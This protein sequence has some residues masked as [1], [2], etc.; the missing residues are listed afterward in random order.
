MDNKAEMNSALGEY[1]ILDLTDEKGLLCGK[2][3]GDL[4]ADVI[5]IEKPGGD[6]ARNI[7]PYYGDKPDPEK[8]LFWFAYNAN[9]RG[10]TLDI[11][12][13]KGKEVFKKLVDDA[14]IVI[15]SF[16]P[17]YLDSI[18]LGYEVLEEINPGI[19]LTSISPFGQTGP[20]KDYKAPDIILW[21]TGGI[22]YLC[23]DSDRAP[24]QVSSPQAYLSG[25]AEAAAATMI[26]LYHRETTGE[27]Q[28][29]DVSIHASIPWIAM[30]GPEFWPMMQRNIKRTGIFRESHGTGVLERQIWRCKD[31]YVHF[32][33]AGGPVGARFMPGLLRWLE[34]EGVNTEAPKEVNWSDFDMHYVS[35]EACDAIVQPLETAMERHTRR[36]IYEGTR[37]FRALV[38]P[39]N[40]P[41]DNLEDLQLNARGF[42]KKLEHGD[43]NATLTYPGPFCKLSETPIRMRRCAPRIGEHNEEVYEKEIG[44]SKE[45]L[46]HLKQQGVI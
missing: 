42:W 21:A 44:L 27:G 16:R 31:G 35:Q 15:E 28:H 41:A 5:K 7:G 19:I 36:E 3:L 6:S 2:I 30:E 10:I 37:K 40:T 33:I 14:D 45:E 32:V 4:G 39:I 23:G 11:E 26:A 29:V 43:L 8:S 20:Y 17:G 12:T 1:R 13:P 25:A 34:E 38:Y 22:M 24:V 46:I 18:S 9:K